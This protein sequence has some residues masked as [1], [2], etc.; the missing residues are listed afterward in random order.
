MSDLQLLQIAR[1]DY[2][3]LSYEAQTALDLEI[4]RRNLLPDND[5]ANLYQAPDFIN[6]NQLPKDTLAFIL[7]QKEKGQPDIY[8]I[9]GLLE[10]NYDEDTATQLVNEIP[11]YIQKRLKEM[12]QLILSSVLFFTAGLSIK[13]LPLSKESHLAIII[14]ADVFMGGGVIGIFHGYLNKKRFS[15]MLKYPNK[16]E[17]SLH[18]I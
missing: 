17:S 5:K 12:S 8:I 14:L 7:E 10:R 11:S 6:L 13:M 4:T 9:G 3:H 2:I 18:N 16:E 15:K 1:E